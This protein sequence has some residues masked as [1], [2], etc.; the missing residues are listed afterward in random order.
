MLGHAIRSR[1]TSLAS[2]FILHSRTIATPPAL[3]HNMINLKDA[4]AGKLRNSWTDEIL[5]TEGLRNMNN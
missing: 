4:L 3:H 2:N 1:L 5:T